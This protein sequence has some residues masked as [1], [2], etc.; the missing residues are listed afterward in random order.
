MVEDYFADIIPAAESALLVDL[1][2]PQDRQQLA[3]RIDGINERYWTDSDW[4]SESEIEGWM[5][6]RTQGDRTWV[7]EGDDIADAVFDL[8][9]AT[10]WLADELR[11]QDDDRLERAWSDTERAIA[12]ARAILTG[13]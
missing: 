9:F 11:G 2:D 4:P 6:N 12:D 7:V 13:R 3:D 1:D 8:E 5:F 10:E